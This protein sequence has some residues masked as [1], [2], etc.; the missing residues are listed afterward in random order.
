LPD[1]EAQLDPSWAVINTTG[2]AIKIIY[3]A[4]LKTWASSPGYGTLKVT[5]PTGFSAPSLNVSDP[6]YFTAAA[7]NGTVYSTLVSGMDIIVRVR[8][9]AAAAGKVT[10]TYGDRTSGG[11]G[12]VTQINEGKPVFY[13][14]MTDNGDTTNGLDSSPS[15][16]L[17]APLGSAVIDPAGV[18]VGS[19]G[20][21][22]ELI[23]TPATSWISG[24]LKIKVPDGF[25]QPSL[26]PLLPGYFTAGATGGILSQV[27]TDGMYILISASGIPN[28][29]GKITVVYGATVGGGTGFDAPSTDGDYA[30]YVESDNSG[31]DTHAI[32]TSPSLHV[33]EATPT[34]T[35]TFTITE[36]Y[37]L[38][39]TI[40]LTPTIS[41][42]PS[43]TTTQMK[44]ATPTKTNSPTGTPTKTITSTFTISMT[45]TISPTF[46]V[47]KTFTSTRTATL[48]KT[49]ADTFTITL[50]RTV[51]N[52]QTPTRTATPTKT[53]TSTK[54]PTFTATQTV[55][56]TFTITPTYTPH[57]VIFADANLGTK[58]RAAIGK[59]SGDTVYSSDLDGLTTLNASAS[60]ITDLTGLEECGGLVILSLYGN[61]ISDISQLSGLLKLNYLDLQS[62]SITAISALVANA[63]SGGLTGSS[64][65]FLKSNPLSSV[66]TDTDIPYL[67]AKGITVSY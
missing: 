62:N 50:T 17:V 25:S 35:M 54:T 57:E 14:A 63:D 44:T 29:T 39:P 6:G 41:L 49:P 64:Q 52:T 42:T 15:M 33:A 58:V 13:T 48:T 20:N 31:A 5:I 36:T 2:N 30:F 23:Y 27:T 55:T 45:Y 3:R 56:P 21:T 47:S 51:T 60:G 7:E 19:S 37:S 10:I 1:G 59:S 12:A 53:Q 8:D 9:L 16:D 66:S 34:V 67:Q 61:N 46:T 26:N 40:T 32:V 28:D 18:L 24:T 65:V 11:P 22:I 4:G 43:K 38:T